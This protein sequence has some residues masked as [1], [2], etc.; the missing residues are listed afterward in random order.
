MFARTLLGTLVILFAMGPALLAHDGGDISTHFNN[1]ARAVKAENDPVQKRAILSHSLETMTSAL[2]KIEH[3]GLFSDKDRVGSKHLKSSLQEK[4]D[5]LNGT[6]SFERVP[7][8]QLNN[9]SDYVVQ[10]MQQ[11]DRYITISAVTLLL[12]IILLVLIL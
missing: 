6:N 3:S 5:E 2:E 10:D 4:Q 1:T 12:I 7:D 9:F 11:A 8:A